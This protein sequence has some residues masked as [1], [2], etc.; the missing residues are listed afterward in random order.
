MSALLRGRKRRNESLTA[1][2]LLWWAGYII[3][4][5]WLQ[6][7]LPGLDALVPA[8]II[9]LQDEN[10]QQTAVFLIVCMAIQE[11]TGTLPFGASI[12]W[13]SIVIATYYVGGWFFMGGNLM[14][15]VVLSVAM[16]V[17]RAVIFFGMGLLQPLSLD[18]ASMYSVYVMQVLLTPLI[19]ALGSKTRMMIVKHAY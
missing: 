12:V 6:K 4:A 11:G 16:G 8:L 1:P 7:L 19:W 10:K 3:A 13:Y 2:N 17:S 5:L 14:F 9:C 18:Y 15:I